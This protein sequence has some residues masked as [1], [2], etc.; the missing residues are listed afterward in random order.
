MVKWAENAKWDE[1]DVKLLGEELVYILELNEITVTEIREH[2]EGMSVEM[3]F[4][5]NAGED[6]YFTV[7][8]ETKEGLGDAIKEYA[9]DFDVDEHVAMWHNS[10][11]SGVPS[12]EELVKDAKSI[13]EFLFNVAAELNG[14]EFDKIEDTEIVLPKELIEKLVKCG[15]L[16]ISDT[17][18]PEMIVD[19]ITELVNAEY[20]AYL[21]EEAIKAQYGQVEEYIKEQLNKETYGKNTIDVSPVSYDDKIGSETMRGW[22]ESYQEMVQNDLAADYPAFEDYFQYQAGLMM[23]NRIFDLEYDLAEEIKGNV[24]DELREA[25]ENYTADMEYYDILEVGGYEGVN[26]D[27]KDFLQEYYINL[28]FATENE[29]NWDMGA[30]QATFSG[31]NLGSFTAEEFENGFDNALSYLVHQQGHKV[32]DVLEAMET[33]SENSF[34]Q[35][36]ADELNNYPQYSMSELTALTSGKKE[37]LD[38]LDNIAHSKDYIQLSPNTEIG[39]YNEWNGAGSSLEIQLE[40]PL[41]IPADMV[42]NVQFESTGRDDYVKPKDYEY[43]VDA[44]YGI[45]K[46]EWS[47]SSMSATADK[48]ELIQESMKDLQAQLKSETQKEKAIKKGQE[49]Y[50]R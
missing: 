23:E 2:E 9:D 5:S 49:E 18:A 21:E 6:F 7:D 43:S 47:K 14:E 28:M 48:P 36:V 8:C 33:S 50:N 24:P 20:D 32:A 4:Y 25:F 39:L 42:R 31:D 22:F 27:A 37:L 38:V 41:V 19:A 17:E 26:F 11:A 45:V 16:D 29:Q 15:K 35:S 46:S 34:V 13:K 10:T 3:R 44:T 1:N 30:I 40:K 12:A